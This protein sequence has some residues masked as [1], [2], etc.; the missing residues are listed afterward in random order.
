MSARPSQHAAEAWQRAE[1]EPT[2]LD[3]LIARAL[4]QADP[5]DVVD[6]LVDLAIRQGVV[7]RLGIDVVEDAIGSAL[8]S[9]LDEESAP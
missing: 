7:R 8:L 4:S 3:R 1:M 6:A 9:V 2:A 5:A